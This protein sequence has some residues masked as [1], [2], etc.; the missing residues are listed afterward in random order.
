MVHNGSSLLNCVSQ[1]SRKADYVA[2]SESIKLGYD[3]RE[4]LTSLKDP[5]N[6]VEM[7]DRSL[8]IK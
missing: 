8:S 4:H 5:T 7:Q 1:S 6:N 2:L 3:S